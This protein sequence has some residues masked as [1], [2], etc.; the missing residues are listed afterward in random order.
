[1][2]RV[3]DVYDK[4]DVSA[5]VTSSIMVKDTKYYPGE[6]GGFLGTDQ[7]IGQNP[8]AKNMSLF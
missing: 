4:I 1:M 8:F 6:S 3:S 5:S 7:R 2:S